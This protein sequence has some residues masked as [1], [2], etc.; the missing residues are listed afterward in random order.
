MNGIDVMWT[1]ILFI[2]LG[3]NQRTKVYFKFSIFLAYS[4]RI[5]TENTSWELFKLTSSVAYNCALNADHYLVR[6]T[7]V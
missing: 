5:A 6:V 1:S 3:P 2:A 7:A 4:I